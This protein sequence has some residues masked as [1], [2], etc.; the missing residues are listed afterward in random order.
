MTN[1]TESQANQPN[2]HEEEI[3]YLA[4]LLGVLCAFVLIAVLIGAGYLLFSGSFKTEKQVHIVDLAEITRIYQEQAKQ[5]GMQ[6]GVSNEQRALILQNLQ[7][8]MQSLQAAIDEYVVECECNVFV[9]SAIVGRSKNVVDASQIIMHQV[10]KKVAQ[11][12]VLTQQ[13]PSQ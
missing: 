7:N 1:T 6:E 12:P 5:Q 3:Y 13:P 8:K 10:E 2:T 11:S 9:K 4:P